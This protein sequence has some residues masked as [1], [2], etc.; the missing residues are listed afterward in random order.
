MKIYKVEKYIYVL[1]RDTK[2]VIKLSHG[3]RNSRI[4][5]NSCL[6]VGRE[7][8]EIGEEFIGYY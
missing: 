3:D 6:S 1:L 4:T 5:S 2:H 8:S 7:W